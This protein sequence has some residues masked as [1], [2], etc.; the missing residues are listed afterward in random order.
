VASP[1]VLPL[2]LAARDG[3]RLAA[4]L[5]LPAGA[6]RLVAL[7]ASAMGVKR[8]LYAPLADFLAEAGIA[9]LRFDYRGIGDSRPRGSLRGFR[10]RLSDWAE[11]DLTA[12]LDE[13]DR[14]FPGVPLA[15]IGHSVGGQLLGLVDGARVDR[16]LLVASQHGHWRLWDGAARY[17]MATLWYAIPAVTA[18]VGYLPMRRMVGGEDV[19]AGVARQWARWGRSRGYLTDYL[20]ERDGTRAFSFAGPLR[21]YAISDDSY[22]PPRTVEGLL[23][24]LPH[25]QRELHVLRPADLGVRAIGHFDLFRD[26]FR[27]SWWT[28]ARSWLLAGPTASR[29]DARDRELASGV[30]AL[31]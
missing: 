3:F 8:R 17:R 26:R 7:V 23:S 11:L 24:A 28:E 2:R 4:D 31:A 1:T 21:S 10:G 13:L 20:H 9:T 6:P 12:A 29:G 30:G 16:A 15:W 14:R 19:P 18:A 22:A 5:H 27:D 25:A